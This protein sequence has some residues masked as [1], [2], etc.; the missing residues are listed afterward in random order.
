MKIYFKKDKERFF[1][2]GRVYDYLLYKGLTVDKKKKSDEGRDNA[3][4]GQGISDK[5]RTDWRL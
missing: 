4:I 2:S 5:G 1:T 3:D